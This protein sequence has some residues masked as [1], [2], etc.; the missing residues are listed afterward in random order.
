MG[1]TDFSIE[2]IAFTTENAENTKGIL[3]NNACHGDA[4]HNVSVSSVS[5]GVEKGLSV[6]INDDKPI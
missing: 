3:R 4:I 6:V 5:S 2:G 1:Y